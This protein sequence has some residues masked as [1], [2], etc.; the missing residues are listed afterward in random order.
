MSQIFIPTVSQLL[1]YARAR[2][3][4][5]NACREATDKGWSPFSCDWPVS[6]EKE[7]QYLKDW[8]ICSDFEEHFSYFLQSVDPEEAFRMVLGPKK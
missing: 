2:I 4:I 5:D 7:I 8:D 6:R 3:S 1:S